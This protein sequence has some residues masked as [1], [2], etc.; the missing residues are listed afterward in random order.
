M[1]KNVAKRALVQDL[2]LLKRD[3]NAQLYCIACYSLFSSSLW[4]DLITGSNVGG[5]LHGLR[6]MDAPAVIN[7]YLIIR[8]NL[9]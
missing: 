3:R 8:E 2:F 7:L 5:M 9:I 4:G 1:T 6:G